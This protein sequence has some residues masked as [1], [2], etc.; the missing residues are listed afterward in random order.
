FS[1]GNAPSAS[2]EMAGTSPAIS[3]KVSL[4]DR[5]YAERR[6]RSLDVPTAVKW[7]KCRIDGAPAAWADVTLDHYATLRQ[8]EIRT[9]GANLVPPRVVLIPR[10]GLRQLLLFLR[11]VL[12]GFGSCGATAGRGDDSAH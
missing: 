10:S 7:R 1:I 12:L 2:I 9:A 3:A 5:W 8:Y 4:Y 11:F 6:E